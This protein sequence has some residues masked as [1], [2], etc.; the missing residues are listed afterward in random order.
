[1]QRETE[2]LMCR[3]KIL[4]KSVCEEK[5]EINLEREKKLIFTE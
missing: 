4:F 3:W 1:M 5:G 2:L